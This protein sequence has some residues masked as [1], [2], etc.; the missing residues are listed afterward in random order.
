MAITNQ[1]ILELAQSEEGKDYVFGS[2]DAYSDPDP[3]S[4]DCSGLVRWVCH[5]LGTKPPMPEGARYQM[6]FCKALGALIPIEEARKTPGALLFRVN[7]PTLHDHVVF[8]LDEDHTFEAR[9]VA[10]GVGSWGIDGRGWTQA[11]K[12]P[13]VD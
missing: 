11:A 6:A 10:Y 8:V 1:D 9:G 7:H 13:G 12:I 5:R 3:D 2:I 4:F